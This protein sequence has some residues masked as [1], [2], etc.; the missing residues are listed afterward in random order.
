MER[1]GK[2]GLMHMIPA[3]Q[4]LLKQNQEFAAV[5]YVKLTT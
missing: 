5:I 3:L 4:I 2:E 1:V